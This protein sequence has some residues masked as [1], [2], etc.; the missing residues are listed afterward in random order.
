MVDLIFYIVKKTVK[1]Q[2][3]YV[4]APLFDVR[5]YIKRD[6]MD[7]L[8]TILDYNATEECL[9]IVGFGIANAEQCWILV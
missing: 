9:G 8:P 2:W 3:K 7:F 1:N 6:Y 4:G 5:I